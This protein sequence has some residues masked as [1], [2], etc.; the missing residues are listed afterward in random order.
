MDVD[1]SDKAWELHLLEFV[2]DEV[3]DRMS[4]LNALGT[5]GEIFPVNIDGHYM[6]GLMKWET[7]WR[8]DVVNVEQTQAYLR[9]ITLELSP[10][11]AVCLAPY[12]LV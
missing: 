6:A 3:A 2:M 8:L 4:E 10:N 5:S 7:L 9:D 12:L 11:Y 1:G